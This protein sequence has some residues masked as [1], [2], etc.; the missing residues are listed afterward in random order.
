FEAMCKEYSGLPRLKPEDRKDVEGRFGPRIAEQRKDAHLQY[1]RAV[2][3]TSWDVALAA[4]EAGDAAALRDG[5]VAPV[6]A[7]G[8]PG[9][10]DRPRYLYGRCSD[11]AERLA[12]LTGEREEA[13]QWFIRGRAFALETVPANQ[14]EETRKRWESERLPAWC[15]EGGRT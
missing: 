13:A 15:P 8:E 5:G 6:R 11:F 2:D 9:G 12:T 10:D 1:L 7:I 4:Y 3:K 14:R